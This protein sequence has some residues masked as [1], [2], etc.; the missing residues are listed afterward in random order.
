MATT[1]VAYSEQQKREQRDHKIARL[2]RSEDGKELVT[3]LNEQ[4]YREMA[5]LKGVRDP[6]DIGRCQGKL[7]IIDRILRMREE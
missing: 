4:S 3:W 6:V 7:D 2:L 5:Q 1:T